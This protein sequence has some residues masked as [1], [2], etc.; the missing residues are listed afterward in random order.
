[1]REISVDHAPARH[2]G[3]KRPVGKVPLFIRY[4]AMAMS[5]LAGR[6]FA[7]GGD[8]ARAA[9]VTMRMITRGLMPVLAVATGVTLATSDAACAAGAPRPVAPSRLGPAQPADGGTLGRPLQNAGPIQLP[10]QFEEDSPEFRRDSCKR[11]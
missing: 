4:A 9:G 11:S 7:C 5:V 6:V 2:A 10:S 3:D 1:M 8:P